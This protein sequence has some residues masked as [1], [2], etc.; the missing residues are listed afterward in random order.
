LDKA[1]D[2]LDNDEMTKVIEANL[3]FENSAFNITPQPYM[4]ILNDAKP[5]VHQIVKELKL[6]DPRASTAADKYSGRFKARYWVRNPEAPFARKKNV[7]ID[8][9]PMA[10][11]LILDRS[12]S[13]I[14][15]ISSLKLAAIAIAR[16]CEELNISLDIWV[17]EGSAQIKSFDERGP[18]VYARIAGIRA[19]GGTD[20]IPTLLA[21]Q[22]SLAKR[23][24]PLKQMLLIHDGVP[25]GF[26][27]TKEL[28]S[29]KEFIGLYAMYVVPP[30][31]DHEL[32]D[33]YIQHGK[34]CMSRLFDPRQFTVAPINRV[35]LEWANFM[36]IF[37]SR[38]ATSIR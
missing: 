35:F 6:P 23:P 24:E 36:K 16:A 22:E 20:M 28:L 30:F 32:S 3:S 7:G 9:P 31:E 27:I 21:A 18:Q 1:T 25:D 37:R 5:L 26:E 13:M 8:V 33:R 4:D 19:A 17:L 15:M 34:E 38:Y 12:G 29:S 2:V 10:L 14:N 11:S